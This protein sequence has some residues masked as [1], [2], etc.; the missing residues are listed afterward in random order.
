MKR[1]KKFCQVSFC[2][3]FF[4]VKV[5]KASVDKKYAMS[6]RDKVSKAGK[7]CSPASAVELAGEKISVRKIYKVTQFLMPMW[8][9]FSY[10]WVFPKVQSMVKHV[11]AW[12]Q[13]V[14]CI[15]AGQL[16]PLIN[17]SLMKLLLIHRKLF[18]YFHWT[19]SNGSYVDSDFFKGKNHVLI[20]HLFELFCFLNF[21]P[22]I[23]KDLCF[24]YWLLTNI[25][26]CFSSSNIYRRCCCCYT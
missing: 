6:M 19:I 4:K 16:E 11:K 13:S 17:Y 9:Q 5:K 3:F 24:W 22:L 14:T 10:F 18:C 23:V 7:Y 15:W 21:F 8:T 1:K 25:E 20:L 2:S 26:M 12:N